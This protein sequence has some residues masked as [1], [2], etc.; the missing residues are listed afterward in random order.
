MR[1]RPTNKDGGEAQ[2]T[3]GSYG[4]KRVA[5]D[6]NKVLSKDGL[7]A[8]RL[9]VA[10]ENKD[11]YLRGLGNERTALSGIV[12]GQVGDN[13]IL[14]LGLTYQDAK[15]RSPM[16]G[17]L[18]LPYANGSLAEFDVSAS[19]SQDWT[20]WNNRMQRAFVEYTHALSPDWE[21]KLTYNHAE[22][23]DATKL[24][25]AYTFT[26]HLN[27]DN[28]GLNG[29]P[30][31]S[32]G[33]S[34]DDNI[35]VNLSGKFNAFGRQHDAVFGLSHSK[36]KTKTETYAGA[37]FPVLPAFPYAGDVFPEPAWGAKTVANE[38]DQQITRLY[39]S[40]RLQ[41]TDCPGLR[42]V[43][44]HLPG[45]GPERRQ[46]R[47]PQAHEGR[48]RRGR[49]QGRV[50]GPQ[51]AVWDG[52]TL[53][54][55]EGQPPLAGYGGDICA[56][57]TVA[58]GGFAVSCPRANGVALFNARANRRRAGAHPLRRPQRTGA[59]ARQPLGRGS[60]TALLAHR[61][62][63]A[64]TLFLRVAGVTALLAMRSSSGERADAVD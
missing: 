26:G 24:F 36:Q 28:T 17:S 10:Q 25:Y 60:L 56:L 7:W 52:R 2:F 9:V 31:R 4:Q 12:E 30:Y 20:R 54:A 32:E 41:L 45:P 27:D 53:R 33:S 34:S 15:Q 63:D 64:A 6:Y 48:E 55:G 23:N 62:S 57:P 37:T 42:L 47:V 8:G 38:G 3:V 13:G 51:I 39:A 18:T 21:A 44:R 29:W 50:A 19:T 43:L 11:S 61:Q 49:R 16:W 46:R 1:K 5:L 22:G 35:D 14:A 40:S 59:A 58:G